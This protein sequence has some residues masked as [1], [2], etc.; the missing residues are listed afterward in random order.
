MLCDGTLVEIKEAVR[1]VEKAWGELQAVLRLAVGPADSPGRTT[2]REKR[3]LAVKLK[4]ANPGKSYRDLAKLSGG[5]L[6]DTY[7]AEVCRELFD[8]EPDPVK[9]A[10]ARAKNKAAEDRKKKNGDK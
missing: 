1:N 3:A 4:L 10:A 7:I 5:V 8:L 6:L 9:A 2:Q